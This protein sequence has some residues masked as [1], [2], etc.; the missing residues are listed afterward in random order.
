MK[1][2]NTTFQNQHGASN[3]DLTIVTNQLLKTVVQWEISDQESASDHNIINYVIGQGDSNQESVD[4]QD[5]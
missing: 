5:V 4:F 3:I 2:L 1:S